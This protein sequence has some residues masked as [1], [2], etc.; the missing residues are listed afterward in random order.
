MTP[1]FQFPRIG[2]TTLSLQGLL[3]V[4]SAVPRNG[5]GT[6]RFRFRGARNA[7]KGPF[8]GRIRRHFPRQTRAS[9]RFVPRCMRLP[10]PAGDGN[11]P[12]LVRTRAHTRVSTHA[13]LTNPDRTRSPTP[14]QTPKPP[15]SIATEGQSQR[16]HNFVRFF[17][18]GRCES[19]FFSGYPSGK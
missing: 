4:P 3:L 1:L 19:R 10:Y 13:T 6:V 18:T 17:E 9:S 16:A 2:P 11:A 14:G 15:A 8:P 7:P 12:I 5:A